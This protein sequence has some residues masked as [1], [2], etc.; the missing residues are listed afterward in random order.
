MGES[1]WVGLWLWGWIVQTLW[2][3]HWSNCTG[4]RIPLAKHYKGVHPSIGAFRDTVTDGSWW[5]WIVVKAAVVIIWSVQ[6]WVISYTQILKGKS[7]RMLTMPPEGNSLLGNDKKGGKEHPGL[8]HTQDKSICT[9]KVEFLF[10]KIDV[11]DIQIHIRHGY[12]AGIAH[13]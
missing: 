1:G 8:S 2:G 4:Q 5:F 3:C 10:N 9:I 11:K 13:A 6:W 12:I 7:E